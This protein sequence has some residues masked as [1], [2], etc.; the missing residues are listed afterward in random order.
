[1]EWHRIK[2]IIIVILLIVNGFLLVLVGTQK[3]ETL[4]YE[5]SALDGSIQVLAENGIT[6]DP[7]A[8]AEKTGRQAGTTERS[9]LLEQKLAAALLGESA[10]GND[11]GGGLY[12][13]TT[14]LGQISIR[15]GGEL[16]SRLTDDS[17]WLTADPESHSAELMDALDIEYQRTVYDVLGGNGKIIYRQM[18]NGVPLFSCQITFI[19]ENGRLTELYGNLLAVAE[20]SLENGTVLSLPTVLMSFLDDVLESGD[21]C[22]AIL[23]VEPGYLMTQSFT[24]TIRLRP[25]WY[26]S[27]NTADYYVDGI[28]GELSRITE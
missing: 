16:T 2:N 27:T 14:E 17:A 21:V 15:S 22:S 1:M 8:I 28:S 4:R 11:L 25:V 26:I 9:L 20:P 10:E 24:S 19:Y 18:L 5:Q 23:S 13:Y 3:S 6:L 12:T 7:E